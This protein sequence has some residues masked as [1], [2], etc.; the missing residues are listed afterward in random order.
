MRD[1]FVDTLN[2]ALGVLVEDPAF[3]PGWEGG[4]RFARVQIVPDDYEVQARIAAPGRGLL[5]EPQ[6]GDEV[7][8]AMP[9]TL[10]D[11]EVVIA[12][13]ANG[14]TKQSITLDPAKLVLG[15]G[16]TGVELR[17]DDT[18]TSQGVV[19]AEFLSDLDSAMGAL[20]QFMTSV[21][22]AVNVAAVIAAAVAFQA[23]P[24]WISFLASLN[25]STSGTGP[26]YAS[27][28]VKATE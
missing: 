5:A 10:E 28:N 6:K 17:V 1:M 25:A 8:V 9:G 12:V 22:G 27:A 11:S 16:K 7:V 2:I 19:L 24:R 14:A 18:A 21:S 3:R 23:D 4:A 20:Q 13:L 26:P 15:V